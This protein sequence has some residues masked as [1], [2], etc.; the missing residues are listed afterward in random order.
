MNLPFS[1]QKILTDQINIP[2]LLIK[3]Y[4]SMSLN[5]IELIVILQILRL[6]KDNELL[7]SFDQ[8]AASMSINSNEVSN[9]LKKLRNNGLLTID[10]FE[11]DQQIVHEWYSIKPLI[12]KLYDVEEQTGQSKEDEGKLFHLFE[13]EFGRALSPIEIETI[14]YW[15][16][17]DRFKP[18]LIKAALREAVLMGK[19]NF[20]YIDRILNEWKKRGIHSVKDAKQQSQNSHSA[21]AQQKET[22]KKRDTSVYYNWLED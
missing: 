18:A 21:N 19:L 20:R 1:Y 13:Q 8:I 3:D 22:V 5:E 4:Q 6:Q 2:A 7:P 12:E 9:V 14:S 15:L 16:D 11:D 10:H 17:D